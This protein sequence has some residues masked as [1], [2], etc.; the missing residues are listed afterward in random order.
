MELPQRCE[1][2]TKKEA[3][4]LK[5]GGGKCGILG[6]NC[7]DQTCATAPT[8]GTLTTTLLCDGYR[9][10]CV[11]NNNLDGCMDLPTTCGARQ[12]AENCEVETTAK[13]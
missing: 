9:S 4:Y 3:C 1:V 11:V 12:K 13:C 10:K 6:S 2:I 8:D 7:V 5:A